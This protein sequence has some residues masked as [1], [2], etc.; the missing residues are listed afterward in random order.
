MEIEDTNLN[1]ED[2]FMEVDGVEEDPS[3]FEEVVENNLKIIR[4]DIFANMQLVPEKRRYTM[5]T[6]I[7]AYCLFIKSKDAYNFIRLVNA[8]PCERVL[9]DTF[10]NNINMIEEQLTDL[11]RIN[12]IITSHEDIIEPQKI[13]VVLSVDAFSTTV[14][15][16][17]NKNDTKNDNKNMFIYML[18]PL[19][20]NY[21]PI[22]V[23]LHNS[24]TGAA[25]ETVS[26]K[27]DQIYESLK[28]SKFNIK[29]C[30]CDGDA[31]YSKFFHFQFDDIVSIFQSENRHNYALYF[32]M[33]KYIWI[34]DP[35]HIFKNGRSRILNNKVIINPEIE[36]QYINSE[37]INNILNLGP[38]LLDKSSVG[39]LRDIYPISIFTI[40]NALTLLLNG[41]IDSFFYVF[42]YSLWNEALLN[43]NLSCETRHFLFELL[44]EILLQIYNKYK[45]I[46]IPENVGFKKSQYKD[47]VSSI[48]RVCKTSCT[49]F[50]HSNE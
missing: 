1:Y 39:K 31:F 21:K 43:R 37:D 50:K 35:L 46:N 40:N 2:V 13:D 30:S 42:V 7:F 5:L 4:N 32:E 12:E 38:A 44:I 45:T 22:I 28:F 6:K 24:P 10:G 11:S 17:D 27:L 33:K 23:H 15:M 36:S 49:H 25:N 9:R 20:T 14:L 29:Y 18:I 16:K 34:T 41:K 26:E 48:V 3:S 8:L 47:Y 19:N